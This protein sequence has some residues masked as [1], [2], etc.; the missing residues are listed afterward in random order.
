MRDG[1]ERRLPDQL[2]IFSERT[3]A[4]PWRS[5]RP[6]RAARS[7]L[8]VVQQNVEAAR[9]YIDP[10]AIAIAHQ[11]QRSADEGLRRDVTDA[12]APRRAGE[13]AVSDQRH[14]LAHALAVDQRRDTKHLAHAGTADRAFVAMN[15]PSPALL[16]PARTTA[17]P[18]P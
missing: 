10:D 5:R 11:R 16:V 17:A 9:L 3:G 18:G 4:M 7:E 2:C 13:A 15:S 14:L 8:I 1:A 6:R 12:H